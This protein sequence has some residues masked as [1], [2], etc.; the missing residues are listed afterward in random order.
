M[1]AGLTKG[2]ELQSGVVS[3]QR[4]THRIVWSPTRKRSIHDWQPGA[5]N[6]R[7]G[8]ESTAGN[9][10]ELPGNTPRKPIVFSRNKPQ[11]WTRKHGWDQV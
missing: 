1:V 7:P 9:S 5:R 8:K 3:V 6:Q 2:S 10:K 11:G 4:P